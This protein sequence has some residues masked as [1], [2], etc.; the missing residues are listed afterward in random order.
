[1]YQRPLLYRG[2]LLR[3]TTEDPSG[4]ESALLRTAGVE[5]FEG[6]WGLRLGFGPLGVRDEVFLRASTP[7][8]TL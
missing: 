8:T 6:L 7:Q 3:G 5:G 2:T 4:Q 1:M